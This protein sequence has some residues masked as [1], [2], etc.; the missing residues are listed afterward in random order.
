MLPICLSAQQPW[1]KSAP[2]TFTWKYVGGAGFTE[3]EAQYISLAFS[4]SDGCPYLAFQDEA[5]YNRATVMK[6]DGTSWV[7]VGNG[8]VK[9][10]F[11]D[12]ICFRF[13]QSGQPYI[14]FSDHNCGGRITV[15]KFDGNNWV[16]V[17]NPGF[18][19]QMY[20]CYASIAISPSDNQPYVAYQDGNLVGRA[21]VKKFNGTDWINVGTGAISVGAASY[22]NLAFDSLG[23]PYVAFSD[24]VYGL[25]ATVMKFTGTNWENIGSPG[26]SANEASYISF[27]IN[28][29]D[30]LP[31]VAYQNVIVTWYATVKKFDG[32]N[33]V[34]V[35]NKDFSYGSAHFLSIAFNLAGQPYVA[36]HDEKYQKVIAKKFD[37]TTWVDVGPSNGFSAGTAYFI[38]LA[39][40]PTGQPYVAYTDIPNSYKASVMKYDSVFSGVN[41]LPGSRLS[42]YPNPV[43]D[44]ITIE[45]PAKG[46]LSILNLSGQELIT[47]QITQPKATID[48]SSL[49]NGVYFVRVKGEKNV[50]T[51]KFVKE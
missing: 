12:Y 29:I 25:K 41:E 28:P 21:T 44:K 49:P 40:S 39:I 42:I 9:E 16:N 10:G 11:A 33:W 30:N 26:F 3:D 7:N 17:G 36:Y 22:E 51:G 5:N 14:A 37:G 19:D 2:M 23:Q 32:Q 27:A 34:D 20:A 35:G 38:S 45:T 31:Y 4:P 15:M 47:R 13:S 48:I 18:S 8:S 43:T 50:E 1:Q 24:S 6:F 46:I